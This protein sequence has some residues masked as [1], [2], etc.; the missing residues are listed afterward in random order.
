MAQLFSYGSTQTLPCRGCGNGFKQFDTVH[1]F[2]KRRWH[3]YCFKCSNPE[4]KK[5][6]YQSGLVANAVGDKPY[7][8]ACYPKFNQTICGGCKCPIVQGK[9]LTMRGIHSKYHP[10]CFVCWKCLKPLEAGFRKRGKAI[11]CPECPIG[12]PVPDAPVMSNPEAPKNS[13]TAE[14]TDAKAVEEVASSVAAVNV[15]STDTDTAPAPAAPAAPA[16]AAAPAP[17]PAAAPAPAPAS[18]PAP[19]AAPAAAA[20]LQKFCGNC[21]TA[22]DGKYC[23]QQTHIHTHLVCYALLIE[24]CMNSTLTSTLLSP[25]HLSTPGACKF[26]TSCGTKFSDA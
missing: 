5:S 4:C 8:S 22:R 25:I 19:A 10:E 13:A 3:N 2:N 20:V 1:V 18:A 17:A 6:L 15:S 24:T 14:A 16:A 26:C 7:C 23:T 9:F 12:G 11:L 21:G